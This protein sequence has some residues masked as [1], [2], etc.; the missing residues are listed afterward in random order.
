MPFSLYL[1]IGVEVLI[2]IVL[3]IVYVPFNK[4][5]FKG[6]NSFWLILLLAFVTVG[7][8]SAGALLWVVLT[9]YGF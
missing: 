4:N 9:E 1:K 5:D 2:L 3:I 8:I 7:L 6:P